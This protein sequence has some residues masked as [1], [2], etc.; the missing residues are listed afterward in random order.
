MTNASRLPPQSADA[1]RKQARIRVGRA[2]VQPHLQ[3]LGVG[4]VGV[5]GS[6]GQ[7]GRGRVWGPFR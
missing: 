7:R 3:E 2:A 1:F 5:E 4:R 6:E